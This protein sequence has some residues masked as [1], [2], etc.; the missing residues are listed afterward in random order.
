M[1]FTIQQ[2]IQCIEREIRMRDQV[3]PRRVE[4]GKM[5]Q[6]QADREINTMRAVLGTLLAVRQM[7]DV[8][9]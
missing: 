2:Q 7:K 6:E 8:A 4:D 3:Y 1:T 5:K 9:P